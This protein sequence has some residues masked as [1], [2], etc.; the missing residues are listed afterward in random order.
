MIETYKNI[1]IS[2]EYQ[3]SAPNLQSRAHFS[4]LVEMSPRSGILQ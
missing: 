2:A 1:N 4:E 3:C